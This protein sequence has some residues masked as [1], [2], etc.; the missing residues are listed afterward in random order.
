[1]KYPSRKLILDSVAKAEMGIIRE[2]LVEFRR[3]Y[4]LNTPLVELLE[5]NEN[6]T[7]LQ[8]YLCIKERMENWYGEF[9]SLREGFESE[10]ARDF[11]RNTA[12]RIKP[13][14]E[15]FDQRLGMLINIMSQMDEPA[16]RFKY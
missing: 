8:A 13:L 15:E 12:E 9:V 11:A 6:M 16:V 10:Y 5:E 4:T 2:Q 7:A 3:I 14:V 1:M